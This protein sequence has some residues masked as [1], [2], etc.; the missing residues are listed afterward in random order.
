MWSETEI[1][2][3]WPL[4]LVLAPRRWMRS[5]RDATLDGQLAVIRVS[6][7][8]GLSGL[9]GWLLR[10]IRRK[11]WLSTLSKL[12]PSKPNQSLGPCWRTAPAQMHLL[13][14]RDAAQRENLEDAFLQACN[15]QVLL[16]HWAMRRMASMPLPL[17]ATQPM[18]S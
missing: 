2:S 17:A 3:A 15:L 5:W 11:A 6:D 16:R 7:G 10:G 8:L 14:K 18:D 1:E 12:S 4:R 9:R 13:T